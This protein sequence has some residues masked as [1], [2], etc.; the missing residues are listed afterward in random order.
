MLIAALAF[1]DTAG[2][3]FHRALGRYANI[4]TI[5]VPKELHRDSLNALLTLLEGHDL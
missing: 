1:G 3:A 5:G 4:T 2:N